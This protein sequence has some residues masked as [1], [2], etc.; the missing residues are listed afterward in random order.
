M[1][2]EKYIQVNSPDVIFEIFDD[3]IV[4]INLE[5]GN[6]YSIANVAAN[7]WKHI[8]NGS[9]IGEIAM[10]VSDVYQGD[11]KEIEGATYRFLEELEQES[12]I[13]FV[14]VEEFTG[15]LKPEPKGNIDDE[16]QNPEFKAP[17]LDRFT[18]MQDLLLLD[19]IHEV[20]E[21]GWPNPLA[22]NS[23]LDE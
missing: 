16:A 13:K 2:Q 3:E 18:D 9:L 21:S 4:L 20:D 15:D 7:I 8:G 22:N 14:D 1:K 17:V 5:N 11:R 10:G 23:E 19:P 12:L 6:Y